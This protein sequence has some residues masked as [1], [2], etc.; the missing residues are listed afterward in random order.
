LNYPSTTTADYET[1]L[2][3]E[4][5][6]GLS[7]MAYVTIN[8]VKPVHATTC[9]FQITFVPRDTSDERETLAYALDVVRVADEGPHAGP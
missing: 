7:V 5:V 3:D 9:A 2:T 4:D 1:A 8:R 6:T